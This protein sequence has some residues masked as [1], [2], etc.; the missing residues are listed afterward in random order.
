[1]RQF[2]PNRKSSQTIV[3]CYNLFRINNLQETY[4]E[5]QHIDFSI[6]INTKYLQ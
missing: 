2:A 5:D 1:M 3:G 6:F 4:F